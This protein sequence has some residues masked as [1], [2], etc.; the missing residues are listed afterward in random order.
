[1][2]HQIFKPKAL[3]ESW[4]NHDKR[5]A[6]TKEAACLLMQGE[7]ITLFDGERRFSMAEIVSHVEWASP[8]AIQ[9]AIQCISFGRLPTS[10]TMDAVFEAAERVAEELVDYVIQDAEEQGKNELIRQAS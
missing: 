3:P 8:I 7:I 4:G 1:M 6:S 9:E 2:K 10:K 5:E